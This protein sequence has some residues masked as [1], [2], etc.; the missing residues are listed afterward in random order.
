MGVAPVRLMRCAKPLL[1]LGWLLSSATAAVAHTGEAVLDRRTAEH[2]WSFE[3][4]V[5]IP[6]VIAAMLFGPGARRRWARPGWSNNEFAAF[7]LGWL[8]LA[9]ALVS[10][11]HELGSLLFWVH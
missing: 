5:V 10:P 1:W 2:A 6:L 3:P 9:V 11:I 8:V 7:C 4:G